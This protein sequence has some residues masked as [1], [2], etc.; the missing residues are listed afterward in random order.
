MGD[1]GCH[2]VSSKGV[3]LRRRYASGSSSDNRATNIRGNCR[4]LGDLNDDLRTRAHG[5][6]ARAARDL[7]A[8]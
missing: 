1:V 3:E 8:A 6:A 5:R 4:D 2:R 7:E